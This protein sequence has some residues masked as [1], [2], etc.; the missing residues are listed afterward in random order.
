MNT[1]TMILDY[2]KK[3]LII[4]YHEKNIIHNSFSYDLQFNGSITG[5]LC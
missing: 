4:L 1:F 5:S 2:N 3:A